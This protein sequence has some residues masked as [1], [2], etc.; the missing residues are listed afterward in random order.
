M[1]W[2][3]HAESPPGKHQWVNLSVAVFSSITTQTFLLSSSQQNNPSSSYSTLPSGDL[4]SPTQS[5]TGSLPE[6][7]PIDYEDRLR[8]TPPI[9]VQMNGLDHGK[10]SLITKPFSSISASFVGTFLPML[11]HQAIRYVSAQPQNSWVAPCGWV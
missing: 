5:P 3:R 9:L 4:T 11:P 1:L 2:R 10:Y 7:P 8:N 6:L